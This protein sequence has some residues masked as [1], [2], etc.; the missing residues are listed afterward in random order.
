VVCER[1]TPVIAGLVHLAALDQR[2]ATEYGIASRWR[3]D[4]AA[5]R[6]LHRRTAC[7]LPICRGTAIG[8]KGILA[9][10]C[11]SIAW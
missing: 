5:D 9:D 3:H 11:Q 10:N 6:A 8:L 2:L 7:R 4:G 1:L